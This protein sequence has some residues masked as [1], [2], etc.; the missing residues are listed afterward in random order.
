MDPIYI[1]AT[2]AEADEY[3][4]SFY[5]ED[6]IWFD[7]GD[8]EKT[9][10]LMNATRWLDRRY[11]SDY[12]GDILDQD[13]PNLFPRT[14]FTDNNGRVI[15]EG[16]IPTTLKQATCEAALFLYEGGDLSGSEERSGISSESVSVGSVSTSTSY[17]GSGTYTD[18]A[19]QVTLL[20]DP[21]LDAGD[22]IAGFSFV[23]VA[24]G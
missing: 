18:E 19:G 8:D 6:A 17:T 20:M 4:K 15:T 7:L 22:G 24:R 23:G 21:I 1:Y 9:P 16:K 14:E 10:L 5:G 13:Q 11:G 12:M 2:I 3:F